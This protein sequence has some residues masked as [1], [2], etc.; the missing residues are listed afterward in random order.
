ME[1]VS[2]DMHYKIGKAEDFKAKEALKES[3]QMVNALTIEN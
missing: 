2:R 3:Q 1:K